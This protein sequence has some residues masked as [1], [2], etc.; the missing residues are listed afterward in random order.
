MQR[1]SVFNGGWTAAAV[2]VVIECTLDLLAQLVNK[3]LVIADQQAGQTRYRLLETV[4]QFA[5][6][7]ALADMET[8][9][10]VQRQHSSDYL[11]LLGEHEERLQSQ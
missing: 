10:Q 2:L 11:C 8:Q 7:H 4:R 3:S 9:R 6:E 1:L 5:A